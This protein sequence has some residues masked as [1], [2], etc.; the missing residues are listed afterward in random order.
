MGGLAVAALRRA[1]IGRVVI[2]NRTRANGSRLAESLAEYDIPAEAVGLED[3]ATQIADADVVVSCTGAVGAVIRQAHVGDRRT[4]LVICDL[5]LPRDVET[6]VGELAGVTVVDLESLQRR[7]S[8]APSGQGAVLAGRIIAEEVQAYLAAQRSA[9]VT[10]TVTALRRRAA[11]VV[12]AEL[13]R[14]DSKLPGLDEGVRDELARTV[15]RVVD[16]LL[17]TP[18]VRVKQL[19]ANPAGAGYADA[20]R[21]LFALDPAKPDVITGSHVDG[22]QE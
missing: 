19:A 8:D 1:E 13:L 18:T 17:H 15:N 11:E 3:L 7:L 6:G 21:E 9:E 22:E 16:K 14:L 5:G 2:A 12:N 10:P 20:L 4:P